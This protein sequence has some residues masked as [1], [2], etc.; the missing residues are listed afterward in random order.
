MGLL[1]LVRLVRP[2]NALMAAAGVMVGILVAGTAIPMPATWMLAGFAAASITAFG[3]VLNDISDAELDRTAHP[4]RPIP[5]GDVAVRT[6]QILAGIAL[7]AGLA[8]AWLAAGLPTLLL[9]AANASLLALYEAKLKAAGLPG[10]LAI[11][12]LVGSTILF[13]AAATGRTPSEWG[14]AWAVAGMAALAN[15]ARELV[16]DVEDMDADRG[17]R[18]TVAL[19]HGP[20]AARLLAFG[21]ACAAVALSIL[22]I[23]R[24]PAAWS[25]TGLSIL[26]PADGVILLGAMWARVSPRRSQLLLKAGM[27]LALAAFAAATTLR[28]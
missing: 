10:N 28:R 17:R 15:L 20:S 9:A 1:D 2:L 7:V 13:G 27:A 21:A 6:A 19:A 3:N 5:A 4:T 24:R 23:L 14:W 25:P 16:K 26:A 18:S 12:F 11:A 8:F 22:P